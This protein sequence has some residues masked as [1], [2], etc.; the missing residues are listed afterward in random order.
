MPVDGDNL[1][2][3]IF[4]S[5]TTGRPKGVMV[6]HR[7]L[8]AIASAWERLYDLRGATRRHL[9]AAP[10]AFD[11][12]TGDWVRAL[13]HRRHAG[14]LPAARPARPGSAG[15]HYPPARIDGLELVPALA[16]AL[17]E[18]LEA[19]RATPLPLRLLAI[20]SDTLRSGLLRRLRRLVAARPAWSTLTA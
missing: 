8:L 17:A 11:V 4:T 14:R 7:A 5:G 19:D 15:R 10:F 16:E 3:I 9:Q 13:D 20:G 6:Q 1:A 2:Y 12:F 18:H